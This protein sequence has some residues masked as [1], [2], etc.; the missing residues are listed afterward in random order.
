MAAYI[1]VDVVV[2]DPVRYD[3]YRKRV[4]A[5][6]DAYGGRFLVRGGKVENLEGTWAPQRFVIVEFPDADT[7]RAW[8][9]S[10]QYAEPKAIRQ[11]ASHTEMILVEGV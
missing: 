6:L 8:W 5:T 7:A 4:Q 2:K 9:N 10:A 3:D 1:V 11:S